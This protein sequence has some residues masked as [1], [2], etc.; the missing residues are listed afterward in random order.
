ML[1]ITDISAI[2]NILN[3]RKSN[4]LTVFATNFTPYTDCLYGEI[5]HNLAKKI[6]KD[7][8]RKNKN[9]TKNLSK[10][11]NNQINSNFADDFFKLSA[12]LVLN[13]N[14]L[15]SLNTYPW[16]KRDCF[17]LRAKGDRFNKI[18]NLYKKY[19]N[20]PI[21]Y[22]FSFFINDIP[23]E[24]FFDEYILKKHADLKDKSINVKINTI[25]I[26]TYKYCENGFKFLKEMAIKHNMSI[27]IFV[28]ELSTD[29][30][31]FFNMS[32][33]FIN[34]QPNIIDKLITIKDID[35]INPDTIELNI[36]ENTINK[37]IKIICKK[38][39]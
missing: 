11:Y 28:L 24:N 10:H 21:L 20:L 19:K 12:M 23:S 9:L 4:D 30:S 16:A 2:D 27:I 8:K 37:P 14:S 29:K 1:K 39:V 38:D 15:D 25:C 26:I 18:K 33:E 13:A 6:D 34:K 3:L 22:M 7:N 35:K 5:I 31:I 17:N 32:Q 36:H